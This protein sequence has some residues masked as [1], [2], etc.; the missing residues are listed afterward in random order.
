MKNLDPLTLLCKEYVQKN[1][2]WAAYAIIDTIALVNPVKADAMQRAAFSRSIKQV[3][4]DVV[5]FLGGKK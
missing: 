3:I 5:Q 1:D 4:A 2:C